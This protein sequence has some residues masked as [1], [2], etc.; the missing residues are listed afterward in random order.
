[1]SYFCFCFYVRSWWCSRSLFQLQSCRG[2][3]VV[4]RLEASNTLIHW[5]FYF[6]LGVIF[7]INFRTLVR[8]LPFVSFYLIGGG[9][10]KI[11]S[12]L[13]SGLIPISIFKHHSWRCL[14]NHKPGIE[15]QSATCKASVSSAQ[16]PYFLFAFYSSVTFVI[17][18]FTI[19]I[20]CSPGSGI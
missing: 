19:H 12:Q 4:L 6:A 14:W 17:H 16:E 10:L 3:H 2:D 7:N 11:K 13:C 5:T 20:L 15:P 1:M 8:L 18:I 9:V